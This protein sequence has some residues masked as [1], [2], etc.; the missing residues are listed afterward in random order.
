MTRRVGDDEFAPRG[1]EVAV[2]NVNGD[3]LLALGAQAV[4]QKRKIKRT[5]G[6]VDFAFLHRS[7]VIFVNGLRVMKQASDERGLAIVHAARSGKAEQILAQVGLEERGKVPRA[8]G[9]GKGQHQK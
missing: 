2:G 7:N 8:L 3:A 4:G 9:S 1:A 5:A 6:A